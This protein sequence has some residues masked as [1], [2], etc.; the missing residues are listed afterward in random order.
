MIWILVTWIIITL[1]DVN[2]KASFEVYEGS[3][4]ILQN[5]YQQ[6]MSI[7]FQWKELSASDVCARNFCLL[8][9]LLNYS[10]SQNKNVRQLKR[11]KNN[12]FLIQRL[13][14]DSCKSIL[15]FFNS[16]FTPLFLQHSIQSQRFCNI[17]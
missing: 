12:V 6:K 3:Y 13:Y 11:Y 4:K 9:V 1:Y 7:S 16:F 17:L 2:E 10:I 5:F 14:N 8:I 15:Q